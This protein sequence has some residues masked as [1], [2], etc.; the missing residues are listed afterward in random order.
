MEPFYV[1]AVD[2]IGTKFIVD[3]SISTVFLEMKY[4]PGR[5]EL[6]ELHDQTELYED[7]CLHCGPEC[8]YGCVCDEDIRNEPDYILE[9]SDKYSRLIANNDDGEIIFQITHLKCKVL[10]QL[11]LEE[12]PN[13]VPGKKVKMCRNGK[14]CKNIEYCKYSH[15]CKFGSKCKFGPNCKYVNVI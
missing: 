3:A 9:I 6:T 10:D 8:F 2:C 14:H 13:L 7:G 1:V 12:Q 11:S 5:Y 15:I 4:A